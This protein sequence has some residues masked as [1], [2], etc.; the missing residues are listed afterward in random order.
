MENGKIGKTKLVI[1]GVSV[2]ILLSGIGLVA[3]TNGALGS[4]DEKSPLFAYRTDSVVG[5]PTNVKVDYVAKETPSVGT[6]G[7]AGGSGGQMASMPITEGC[8]C[9]FF[10][11][12]SPAP[13]SDSWEYPGGCIG[14]RDPNAPQPPTPIRTEGCTTFELDC[15]SLL[16]LCEPDI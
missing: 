16:P 7:Q 13:L 3:A 5:T 10:G 1:T 8:I 15:D 14:P 2:F 11:F 4:S 12:C 6:D 9:T